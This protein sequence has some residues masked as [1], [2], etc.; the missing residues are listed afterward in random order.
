MSFYDANNMPIYAGSIL[1]SPNI[2]RQSTP[3]IPQ[4]QTILALGSTGPPSM[5]APSAPA[6]AATGFGG[7][8]PRGRILAAV[9]GLGR[10]NQ[11]DGT[12]VNPSGLPI[13]RLST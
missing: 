9:G 3:R 6:P 2:V 11:S 7:K 12:I 8:A 10:S 1:A 4:T 13:V 5:S